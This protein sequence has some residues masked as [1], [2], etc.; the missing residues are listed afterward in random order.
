MK[1]E[2]SK[3]LEDQHTITTT[4]MMKCRRSAEEK[5]PTDYLRREFIEALGPHPSS[6]ACRFN[7]MKPSRRTSEVF[8]PNRSWDNIS[9]CWRAS[10][11]SPLPDSFIENC[12]FAMAH[13]KLP[14][15]LPSTAPKI[16][17]P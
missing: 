7:F 5:R 1:D 11:H 9:R 8:N 6:T 14:L 17:I 16:T 13:A 3:E 12:S 15:T 10:L 2:P 4:H